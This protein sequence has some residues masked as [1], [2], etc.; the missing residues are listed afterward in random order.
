ML[1]D[2]R[3]KKTKIILKHTLISLLEEKTFE[4]ITVKELCDR[5]DT[6]R[7]TFYNHYNDKYELI[8]EIFQDFIGEVV[9]ESQPCNNVLEEYV[10]GL[11][12]LLE[13]N[14]KKMDDNRNFFSHLT[15]EEN[16]YP[17]YAL[18]NY[19]KKQLDL[20]IKHFNEDNR[21][22][23]NYPSNKIS[24]FLYHGM[25]AFII[26]SIHQKR[27]VEETSAEAKNLLTKLINSEIFMKKI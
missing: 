20:Y 2:K 3:I 10:S 8:D 9:I 22:N 21:I 23:F 15:P 18:N 17:S 24:S 27:T 26:E 16:P 6:S 7:I 4:K 14:I 25:S 5:S 12:N 13:C 1:E 11:C 19:L